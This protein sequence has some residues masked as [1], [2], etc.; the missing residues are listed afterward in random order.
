MTPSA[1]ISPGR[2]LGRCRP[3][4][5]SA[6]LAAALGRDPA[7]PLLTYYDD[8]T[9]E[10]TELSVATFANWVAKTANL[11]RDDLGVQPGGLVAVD[12][13]LH[14]QAAVWLQSCWE[15]GLVVRLG[16]GVPGAML[17]VCRRRGRVPRAARRR[18]RAGRRGGVAGPGTDG[19][20]PAGL[21]AG[22]RPGSRLRP[23]GARPRR[24]VRPRPDALTRRPGADDTDR[25]A[26][27]GGPGD[28][29]RPPSAARIA[30]GHRAPDHDVGGAR[31]CPRPVGNR[32]HSS[33]LPSPRPQPARRAAWSRRTSLPASP[34]AATR[35]A[36][37]PRGRPRSRGWPKMARQPAARAASAPPVSRAGH[38][39]DLPC[40]PDE[41]LIASGETARWSAPLAARSPRRALATPPTGPDRDRRDARRPRGHRLGHRLRRL[42][43]AQRQ[44][45]PGADR[46]A[47]R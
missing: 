34:A 23:G 11:L 3:P 26:H 18:H 44:H 40:A 15:L 22:V 28:G 43:A 36:G 12:L 17:P 27:G 24:P 8:A 32:R 1:A 30:A 46:R 9:G 16:P 13:P 38:R 10:R 14:W 4:T 39:P 29:C 42:P 41:G 25:H 45:R 2:T 7:R 19:A 20:G 6:L 35:P 33:A 37:C 47:A 31:R 21:L 5:P